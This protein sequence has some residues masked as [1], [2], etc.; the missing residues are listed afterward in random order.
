MISRIT[1]IMVTLLPEP[2]SPTMPSTSP[3]ATSIE[4]PSTARSTPSSVR[5]E[6]LRSLM[7]R[8]FSLTGWSGQPDPRVEPG[9]GDIHQRVGEDDE[10]RAVDHG[11]HDHRQI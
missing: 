7:S 2:D 10:E 6:T 11:R 3:L 1:D 5:N 8:S 4:T 9:V